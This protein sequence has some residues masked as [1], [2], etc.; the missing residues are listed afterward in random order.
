MGTT[1]SDG[2]DFRRPYTIFV[3]GNVGSGKSTTLK[4]FSNRTGE[5]NVQKIV[6]KDHIITHIKLSQYDTLIHMYLTADVDIVFEPVAQ[7][8]NFSGTNFLKLFFEDPK[9]WTGA[10]TQLNSLTR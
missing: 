10:F 4:F 9:R 2:G 1:L 6:L 5:K 3:E 8:Q 7:W